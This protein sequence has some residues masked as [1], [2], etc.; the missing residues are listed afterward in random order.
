M[1]RSTITALALISLVP[2]TAS[3]QDWDI[4][5]GNEDSEELAIRATLAST[6]GSLHI[7][8][9]C[10]RV[11]V[12]TYGE[13]FILSVGGED[14]MGGLVG[15]KSGK[16]RYHFDDKAQRDSQDDPRAVGGVD[17]RPASSR[18]RGK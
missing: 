1:L 10:A 16:A 14:H 12:D 6:S 7:S 15:G 3:A 2:L 4:R 9:V 13:A 18:F 17:R 11:R 5:R 8:F